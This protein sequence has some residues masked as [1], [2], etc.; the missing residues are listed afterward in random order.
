[1]ADSGRDVRDSMQK[2]RRTKVSVIDGQIDEAV[3]VS[4]S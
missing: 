1:M 3:V 4:Q 2:H